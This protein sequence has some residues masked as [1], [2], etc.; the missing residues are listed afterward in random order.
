MADSD[1][2]YVEDLSD[3]NFE[4]HQVTTTKSDYGTRSKGRGGALVSRPRAAKRKKTGA[5]GGRKAAWEITSRSWE[6]VEETTDGNI[7]LV[8]WLEGEKR[9]RVRKDTK[10]LQ[11]GII[12]HLMLVLDMSFAMADKDLLPQRYL[13]T[14]TYAAEFV[15]EFYEQN[16]ISQLGIVGMRDGIAI[17]ISDTG[18]N[19]TEHIERLREFHKSEPTGGPSLQNALEM[20]RGVLLW[21]YLQASRRDML[22]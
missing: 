5:G 9:R 18:G 2:E 17:R 4:D 21:A 14:L 7:A 16:P 6:E 20:C 22:Y 8:E 12:R 1:D 13:L 19:P 15:R 10:P 3:D 11:R